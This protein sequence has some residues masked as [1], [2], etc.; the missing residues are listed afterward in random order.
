MA[1]AS[2]QDYIARVR[3]SNALPPPPNPPKLLDVPNTGLSGGQ[4]TSAGFASRLAREQPLN[5]EADA[6]LGMPIDL[7]GI[8]GVFEGNEQYIS[9]SDHIPPVHPH[10]KA[11]LRPLA[12]LGKPLSQAYGV[13][14]LRRTEYITALQGGSRDPSSAMLRQKTTEKR[15]KKPNVSDDDPINILRSIIKGFDVA[16][17]HDKYTGPD[18]PSNIRGAQTTAAE[19]EAWERPRHPTKPHLRVLDSYPV[20]PDFAAVPDTG[21][22][23][24][25][26]FN[27]NPV[28]PTDKYDDRLDV[29][30]LFPQNPPPHELAR[31]REQEKARKHDPSA[32]FAIPFYHYDFF[33]PSADSV[34]PIKRKFDVLDDDNDG[35]KLY[36]WESGVPETKGMKSFKYDRVRHY[37]TYQQA[38]EGPDDCFTDTVG[39][40]LHDPEAT[41]TGVSSGKQKAAY[42]YGISQRT[43]IRPKRAK[44]SA[45]AAT[46]ATS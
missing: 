2:R 17:P 12:A 45:S 24:V 40:A 14:F 13:S 44:M 39:V 15:F 3:Y 46:G 37:E 4:Y 32:Q 36:T 30:I 25:V 38:G 16:Y 20:L 18:T 7:I 10:D 33:M 23:I 6:E 9:T 21:A 22:Y 26:K 8:P 19:K 29:G 43:F 31:Y 11:L 5:I 42:L 28:G 1:G 34:R 35:D 41:E 27:P